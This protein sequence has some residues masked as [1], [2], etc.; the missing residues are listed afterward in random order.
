MDLDPAK[1][2]ALLEGAVDKY[3]KQQA[4]NTVVNN[5]EHDEARVGY[6]RVAGGG[7][8]EFCQM[9]SSRG[10]AFGSPEAAHASDGFHAHCS[11]GLAVAFKDGRGRIRAEGVDG[12]IPDDWD[13][14]ELYQ[15]YAESGK[16]FSHNRERENASRRAMR[17]DEGGAGAGKPPMRPPRKTGGD[18]DWRKRRDAAEKKEKPIQKELNEK[19]SA[20]QEEKTSEVYDSTVRQAILRHFAGYENF[21]EVETGAKVL[22]KEISTAR[23]L[24]RKGHHVRFRAP[25]YGYKQGNPDFFVDKRFIA[26]FKRIESENPNKIF[27]HV[28]HAVL[29]QGA[30]CVVVDLSFESIGIEDAILMAGRAIENPSI[31]VKQI[32]MLYGKGT[33]VIMP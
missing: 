6:A 19:W 10:F 4:R 27:N 22:A 16:R 20:Y 14:A 28:K 9:Q 5:V 2:L 30:E 8:C 29:D 24:V 32:I 26:D 12:E 17:R 25:A 21:V 11:C 3:V 7:A 15:Q 31:P 1:A 18:G 23:L 33:E 13:P